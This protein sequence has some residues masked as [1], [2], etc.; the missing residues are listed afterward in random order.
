MVSG[1]LLGTTVAEQHCC[2]YAEND[3]RCSFSSL[4]HEKHTTPRRATKRNLV[5]MTLV[6]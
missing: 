6:D 4:L 2:R 5:N 3:T 1:S